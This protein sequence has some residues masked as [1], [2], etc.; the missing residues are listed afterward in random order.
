M[1]ERMYGTGYVKDER[2]K[3]AMDEAGN[4]S[5]MFTMLVLW[6]FLVW[7][8]LTKKNDMMLPGLIIFMLVSL[9]Y[10]VSLIRKGAISYKNDGARKAVSTRRKA[11]AFIVGGAVYGIFNMAFKWFAD[12]AM[13][14]ENLLINAIS[15]VVMAVIWVAL[16]FGIIQFISWLSSRITEKKITPE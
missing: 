15:C 5:F 3:A 11:V 9:F 10:L 1:N 12:P 6:V 13:F 16:F 14:K 4:H 2:I 8:L 7:I